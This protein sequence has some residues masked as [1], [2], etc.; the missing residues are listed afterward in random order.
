MSRTLMVRYCYT[1][2]RNHVN[3]HLISEIVALRLLDPI[4]RLLLPG[5]LGI[6]Q[7]KTDSRNLDMIPFQETQELLSEHRDW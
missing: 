6:L 3:T 5:Y 4:Q 2:G 1:Y 7:A